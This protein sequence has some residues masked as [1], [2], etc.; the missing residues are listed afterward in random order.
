[1]SRDLGSKPPSISTVGDACFAELQQFLAANPSSE[2]PEDILASL[3]LLY[4]KNLAKALEVVDGGGI[5]C[6]EGARTRRRVFRVPARKPADAYTVF[7]SHY[8]SCQ[9]FQFDVVGRGEAV[10]VSVRRAG[11]VVAT[12]SCADG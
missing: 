4:G 5:V 1:M 8:C 12:A 10:C 11:A 6:Y 9:S 2:I 7:P 3:H